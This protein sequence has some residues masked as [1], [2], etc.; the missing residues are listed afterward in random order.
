MNHKEKS[1]IFWNRYF[2][3]HEAF[4]INNE[5]I[6][7]SSTFDK[8]L[9]I[10]GDQAESILDIGCG[11]GYCLIGSHLLGEKVKQGVGFDA[12]NNAIRVAKMSLEQMQIKNVNFYEQDESFLDTLEDESF[13][14]IICSNFL[15]VISNEISEK[16][17]LHISRL[18]KPKGLLLLKLNFYLNEELIQKFDMELLTENTYL[19]QGVIRS[20]NLTTEQWINKFPNFDLLK[21]DFYRRADHLPEDRILLLLKK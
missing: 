4:K 16:T 2:E 5:D 12:S 9:K 17:I 21:K 13:D 8:Y 19:M 14:G 11:V 3:K 20:H 1:I 7:I 18:L 15:D 10:I 6:K